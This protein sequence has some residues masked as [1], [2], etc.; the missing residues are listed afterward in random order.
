MTGHRQ[1]RRVLVVDDEK[2]IADTLAQILIASG[3]SAEVAYSGEEAVE[4]AKWV[5]P[6]VLIADVIMGG[7]NGV[8]SAMSI[9]NAVPECRVILCSG[10]IKS[11]ELVHKAEDLGYRFEFMLKPVHPNVLLK[12]LKHLLRVDGAA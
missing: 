9:K 7:I 8:E 10:Q 1:L 4:M 2:I 11:E 12:R 6:D 3:F 5:H